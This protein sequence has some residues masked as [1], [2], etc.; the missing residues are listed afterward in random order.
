VSI[1]FVAQRPCG[2]KHQQWAQ[3][4]A[5]TGDDVVADGFDERDSR[6]PRLSWI[7]EMTNESNDADSL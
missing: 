2:Q 6:L 3:P 7:G 5:A 4:L 1:A